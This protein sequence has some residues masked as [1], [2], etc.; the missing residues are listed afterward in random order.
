[1][2]TAATA[3]PTT[4]A[5]SG[6]DEAPSGGTSATGAGGV[7]A[8][9]ANLLGLDDLDLDDVKDTAVEH[10]AVKAARNKRPKLTHA[11]LF[12]D[13]DGLKRVVRDFPKI[14]FKGKGHEFDDLKFMMGHYHKWVNDFHPYEKCM[15]DFVIAA[16]VVLSSKQKS[17]DGFYSD[18]REKLH[19]FRAD[20]KSAGGVGTVGARVA[21]RKLKEASKPA[22]P[23]VLSEEVRQRIEANRQRAL[24]LQRKKAAAALEAEAAALAEMEA[25]VAGAEAGMDS[26][27]PAASAA[28]GARTGAVPPATGTKRVASFDDEEDDPFGF[29]FGMDDD[30]FGPPPPKPPAPAAPAAAPPAAAA[31]A[32]V[33]AKPALASFD[34]DEDV[35]GFGFG[36]DEDM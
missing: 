29:G 18:P 14:R 2:A 1:M 33:P 16:R 27:A 24:E 15:E 20:Y 9:M 6:G 13:E 8:A 10:P 22:A 4:S 32:A 26:V 31:A 3:P 23:V 25:L 7:S 36:M 11:R 34:D 21:A 17:E 28:T 19:H 5:A 35:F 12:D 30:D